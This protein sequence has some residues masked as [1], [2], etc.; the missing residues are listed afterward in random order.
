[1]YTHDAGDGSSDQVRP[2]L[3]WSRREGLE[4]AD[5]ARV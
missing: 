3:S 1:M 5:G 4:S 2:E